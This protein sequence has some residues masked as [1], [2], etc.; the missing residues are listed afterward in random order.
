MT[1]LPGFYLAC[2]VL[3]SAVSFGALS[4]NAQAFPISALDAGPASEVTLV[5]GGCGPGY[6]RG[7]YGGCRANAVVVTPGV[8]IAPAAP[9]VVVPRRVCP[10]GMHFSSYRGRCVLN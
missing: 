8:V 9:V 3:G 6:H 2:T 4:F 5:A 10:L 1:K 7:P